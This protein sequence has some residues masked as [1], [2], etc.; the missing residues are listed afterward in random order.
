LLVV[1]HFTQTYT[2]KKHRLT[3]KLEAH[4]ITESTD[5]P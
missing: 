4:N 5:L 3:Q 1:E 2:D